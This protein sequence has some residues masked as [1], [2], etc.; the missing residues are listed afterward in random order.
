MT[1][2]A[3]STRSD[4]ARF[5]GRRRRPSAGRPDRGRP[6]RQGRRRGRCQSRCLFEPER[7]AQTQLNIGKS[8]FFDERINTTGSGLVQVLLVDGSTFTV[9][10]GSDLVID[11]FVYDPNKKS[12]EVVASFSKGV[13]RFV[14]GKI[15]KNEGGVTVNTPSG[16]LAIRGGM[17]QG[18]VTGGKGVFS[19]LYGVNMTLTGKNG[20]QFTVFQPGN[21][22]DTTSGTP[23]I[24]PTTTGDV[25]AFMNALSKGGTVVTLGGSNDKTNT[26][27]GPP[28]QVVYE[29][30]SLQDLI[31]DATQ[32]SINDQ[33]QNQEDKGTTTTPTDTTTTPT[34]TTTTPTDTTTP[35]PP[36]TVTARVLLSPG[37]YTAFPGTPDQYTT[38]G[39][40][41]SNGVKQGILGG[42]NYPEGTPPPLA[43]DFVW[44]FGFAN[45]RLVGTVSG[46]TDAH[47][48]GGCNDLQITNPPPAAVNFPST[49][50]PA[51][52]VNGVCAVTDATITQGG[53][54]TTY[55]G[56]A[57]L[58]TGFFAYQLIGAP[59]N[60]LS[61]GTHAELVDNH[62]PSPDPLLV[63]GGKGYNFG[64][65]S[66]Q[67]FAF[68]LTPDVKE[69]L[70]GAIAPFSGGGSAPVVPV[71]ENGHIIGPPPSISPLLYKETDGNNPL[72]RAVWLQ[73]SLYI[74]TTPA[75]PGSE[76]SFDQ[77][78]FVNV[79]LGGVDPNTGGLAGA[80][81]GGS[82]ADVLDFG[83][84]SSDCGTHRDQIAF[85]GDIATLA[86]PD[87]SHFLGKDNPNIVIGFDFDRHSQ[88]RPRH[89]A[90]SERSG[91]IRPGSVR[92]DL[93]CRRR[94]WAVAGPAADL[95]RRV[96]RLCGRSLYAAL[97]TSRT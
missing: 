14:G 83:C 63:F 23:T 26:A 80:R 43:D 93:S 95:R 37:V 85:T 29:T 7:L 55:Q 22:I 56:L 45:G 82:S 47:C 31:S 8:I 91:H 40:D 28:K 10:P 79:A 66:G 57:V 15:S 4:S 89:S 42:G 49:F 52:C 86:G 27:G 71:D 18:S 74:N 61:I 32:T 12:G 62:A 87:G 17:F 1:K 77:Q 24:R 50:N 88:Y 75:D 70:N 19:F 21:T 51:D 97:R 46:L 78:S 16:A 48:G 33:V 25:N 64:T 34:D 73:T 90:R 92:L 9:G 20:Q 30:L 53:K 39:G 6:C 65:P 68:E 5:G 41:Q 44:T 81:R 59:N 96:Q 2:T 35:P 11:K 69:A 13:M 3:P 38:D 94:P 54:T 36:D 58:K 76:T 60:D 84:N 72:S 67:I